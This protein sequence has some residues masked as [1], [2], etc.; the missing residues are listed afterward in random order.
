MKFLSIL[1]SYTG[2]HQTQKLSYFLP[3]AHPIHGLQVSASR[4]EKNSGWSVQIIP[5]ITGLQD[6]GFTS[7]SVI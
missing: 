7:V 4:K 3:N 5:V 2:L 6:Y 1:F